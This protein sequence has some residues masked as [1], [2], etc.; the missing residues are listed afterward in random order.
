MIQRPPSGP[1]HARTWTWGVGDRIQGRYDIL[2]LAVGG[3][4]FVFLVYDV[5]W[6]RPYAIKV[7]RPELA[8]KAENLERFQREALL[9]V[10][11]GTHPCIVTAEMVQTMGGTACLFLEYV[12]GGD[13]ASRLSQGPPALEQGLRWAIQFCLGLAHANRTLGIVH[14]DVKPSNALITLEGNVKVTDFGISRAPKSTPD[15]DPAAVAERTDLYVSTDGSVG[16]TLAYIAPET[17]TGSFDVRSDIFSFGCTLYEILTSRPVFVGSTTHELIS[18]RLVPVD[19]AGLPEIGQV[20]QTL[21]PI[22]QKTLEQDP[23]ARYPTF[24]ELAQDLMA[25]YEH[26]CGL[27]FS[28]PPQVP[29]DSANALHNRGSSLANLGF[30]KDAA[31]Y[32]R[33]A[34]ALAPDM[35]DT[36]VLLGDALVGA[37]DIDGGIEVFSRALMRD[38][39]DDRARMS[40]AKALAALGDFHGALEQLAMLRQSATFFVPASFMGARILQQMGYV[41]EAKT[42]TVGVPERRRTTALDNL[43]TTE[44]LEVQASF[45]VTPFRQRQVKQLKARRG[46]FQAEGFVVELRGE[47]VEIP[48]RD[49]SL[50]HLGNVKD[51][52][53]AGASGHRVWHYLMDVHLAGH[54]LRFDSRHMAF[55]AFLEKDIAG[56]ESINMVRIMEKFAR[57]APHCRLDPSPKEL[58]QA[59]P[60]SFKRY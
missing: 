10:G 53:L 56:S 4:A 36:E 3:M 18:S 2:D 30:F 12:E 55:P 15:G 16:G 20:P 14:R 1:A 42:W 23:D 57:F 49:I 24:D 45:R 5:Q 47:E 26:L 6:Q 9:W 60:L 8:E 50:V 25:A 29:A 51:T 38:P 39:H 27:P 44:D 52:S 48:W 37:G 46:R 31:E 11:L 17:L 19:L 32:Y 13:L 41:E 21:L 35:P 22:L 34:L 58:A 40:L 54:L 43:A 59:G 33:K 28:M 7:L